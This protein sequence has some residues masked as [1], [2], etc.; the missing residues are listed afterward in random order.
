MTN[1][2]DIE[3]IKKSAAKSKVLSIRVS[4]EIQEWIKKEDISASKL[5]NK[6]AKVIMETNKE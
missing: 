5:F 3:K 2:I 1:E 4:K 6:A